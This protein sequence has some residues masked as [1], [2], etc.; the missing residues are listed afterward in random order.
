M[1]SIVGTGKS[2]SM[3]GFSQSGLNC[4][5]QANALIQNRFAGPEGSVPIN[6]LR[7]SSFA[8]SLLSDPCHAGDVL[9]DELIR[10]R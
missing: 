5:Q 9:F 2:V 8:Q 10:S 1:I 7:D 3:H 4:C 6:A